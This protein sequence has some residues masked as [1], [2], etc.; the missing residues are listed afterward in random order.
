MQRMSYLY[1]LHCAVRLRLVQRAVLPGHKHGSH[2]RHMR[3]HLGVDVGSVHDVAS[4]TM[5]YA[6]GVI[7]G[8]GLYQM[9][10]LQS[11]EELTVETPFGSPSDVILRGTLGNTTMLF[12]PRHGRG[13]RLS[14]SNIPY[15]AN[16]WA[17]KSL[18]ATHVVSVS[19]VGSLREDIVPG[20]VVVPRQFI[21]RTH[22]R[23][24]T[25][26]DSDVVAHVSTADPVCPLLADALAEASRVVDVA[27]HRHNTY[28]CIEGPRFSTRAESHLFRSWGADVIGMTGL[29]E[30]FLAREAE[31]PYATLALPTDYDC[32]RP[33]EQVDIADILAVL[34]RSVSHAQQILHALAAE[35][36]DPSRS[37]AAH[38]MQHAT[39]T[40]PNALPAD[41]RVRYRLLLGH[42]LGL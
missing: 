17:L 37:P 6:L 16:I 19:A 14:P 13:H 25:F 21:D 35:L 2:R 7:G 40:H 3:G 1:R 42:H 29:P 12:V 5:S 4:R 38:A 26:F 24:N 41:V 28:V 22:G 9:P 39:M 23:K 31:L 30:A 36:P 10:G 20:D 27:V 11:V 8:S 32:W 33:N 18:G 15:R 34:Q